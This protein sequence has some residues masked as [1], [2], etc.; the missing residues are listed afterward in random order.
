MLPSRVAALMEARL[1]PPELH[2]VEHGSLDK[3]R[4][5]LALPQHGLELGTKLRLDTDLRNDG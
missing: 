4:D 3:T 1:Y 2:G 5:G